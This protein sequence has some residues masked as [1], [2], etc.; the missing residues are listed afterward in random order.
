MNKSEQRVV[1]NP[2]A[3]WQ[4][5]LISRIARIDWNEIDVIGEIRGFQKPEINLE[6][7]LS[8]AKRTGTPVSP[9][10]GQR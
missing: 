7:A 10:V 8:L 6:S 2:Q 1:P 4:K 5:P 9:G 3:I